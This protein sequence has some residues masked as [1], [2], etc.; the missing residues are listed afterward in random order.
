MAEISTS[1]RVEHEKRTQFAGSAVLGQT[2]K[3]AGSRTSE[4]LVRIRGAVR[5]K[6]PTQA[7]PVIPYSFG[8]FP[9]DETIGAN[10][11]LRQDNVCPAFSLHTYHMVYHGKFS[12]ART[13]GFSGRL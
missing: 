2:E 5:S 12:S 8:A 7:L 10:V 6:Y 3:S 11:A 13:G 1:I 9:S 4:L